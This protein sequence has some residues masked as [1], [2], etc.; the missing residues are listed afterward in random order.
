MQQRLLKEKINQ[1]YSD[2]LDNVL[3]SSKAKIVTQSEECLDL[4]NFIK[5][6]I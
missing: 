6:E 3:N 4:S 5:L 1:V 2:C